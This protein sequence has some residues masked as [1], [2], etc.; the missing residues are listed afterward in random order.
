MATQ[1]T[2]QKQWFKTLAPASLDGVHLGDVRAKREEE[3][4]G[5]TLTVNLSNVLDDPRKQSTEV[6]FEVVATD[7]SKGHTEI[8]HVGMTQSAVRR[9]VRKGR[10]RVDD[11]F[12]VE[13]RDGKTM[14]LKPFIVT[15]SRVTNAV[16]TALRKEA[17]KAVKEYL[18]DHDADQYF[19]DVIKNTLQRQ[20]KDRLSKVTPLRYFDIRQS[21]VE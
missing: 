6:T 8:T 5:K 15:S 4:I 2:Q 13:S 20:I 7:D 21:R 9:M 12:T 11:S 3:I 14:R 19:E 18:E 17:R 1:Q 16:A 10:T